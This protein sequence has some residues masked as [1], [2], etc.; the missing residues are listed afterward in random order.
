M[1]G[2]SACIC[3]TD[4]S[5]FVTTKTQGSRGSCTNIASC[6]GNRNFTKYTSGCNNNNAVTYNLSSVVKG[7][8]IYASD[9]NN[10]YSTLQK[11]AQRRKKSNTFANVAKSALIYANDYNKMSSSQVLTITKVNI[12]D[13]IY[14]NR[15]Q[16][17]INTVKDAGKQ[18]LCHCN[19]C[20]C[21]CNVCTCDCNNCA[22]HT[23]Y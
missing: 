14:A 3:N 2:T 15:I 8:I 4:S 1:A 12:G 5:L 18:C 17:V 7:N 13:I 6:N 20:S 11:E 23:H 22:C 10:L 19:Y 16:D 21:D 9:F